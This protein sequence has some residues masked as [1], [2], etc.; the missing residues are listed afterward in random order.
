MSSVYTA[1]FVLLAVMVFVNVL[2]AVRLRSSLPLFYGTALLC[3]GIGQGFQAAGHDTPWVS[4][5][6]AVFAAVFIDRLLLLRRHAAFLRPALYASAFAVVFTGAV[7]W[8]FPGAP[9]LRAMYAAS[10]G[11]I[12]CLAAALFFTVRRGF[13]PALY[14]A[15]GLS[16]FLLGAAVHVSSR[17][18]GLP[19]ADWI[20]FALLAGF[21]AEFAF[22]LVSITVVASP[23]GTGA[24]NDAAANEE[25]GKRYE[26]RRLDAGRA[27]ELGRRLAQC[28]DDERLYCDE[29]LSLDRLADLCEVSRHELSEYLNYH[30][31]VNFNRYVNEF[32]VREVERL[33][34]ESPNRTI[35][36]A[37]FSAGFNS[38]SRFN[39]E[40]RRI[41]GRN[42]RDYRRNL[43]KVK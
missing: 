38:K 10:A 16:L 26:R 17:L 13:R 43:E 42:P 9:A 41:T 20:H 14:S 7:A 33:L 31:G 15:I 12:T 23:G 22:F 2:L 30:L 8:I 34:R 27:T 24:E 21:F 11:F 5:P 6:A 18:G 19:D 37:A 32:R 39:S 29:D 40:F 4:A 35:L 36:D 1:F 3:F 25:H 28:M